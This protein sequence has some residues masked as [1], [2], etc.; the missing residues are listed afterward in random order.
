MVK[1]RFFQFSKK[2]I[3]DGERREGRKTSKS[4]MDRKISNSSRR[5]S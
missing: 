2:R 1:H 5:P 4:D 3:K